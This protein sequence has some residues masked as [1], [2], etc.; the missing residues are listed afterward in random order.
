MTCIGVVTYFSAW[1]VLLWC[2]FFPWNVVLFHQAPVAFGIILLSSST[3]PLH[4]LS[5]LIGLSSLLLSEGLFHFVLSKVMFFFSLPDSVPLREM[6]WWMSLPLHPLSALF[7]ASAGHHSWHTVSLKSPCLSQPL[8]WG[9][10]GFPLLFQYIFSPS[11]FSP[12]LKI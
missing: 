7:S 6:V 3:H 2:L 4:L 12:K 5:F 11:V 8:A 10:A 1:Q 9:I